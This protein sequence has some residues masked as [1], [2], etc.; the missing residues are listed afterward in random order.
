MVTLKR[1]IRM[2]LKYSVVRSNR[3]TVSM[4]ITPE[5][6]VLIRA[7]R[8]MSESAIE[9]FASEHEMWAEEHIEKMRLRMQNHPEPDDETKKILREK[10][11][12]TIPP[13]VEK[14]AHLMGVC[15]TGIKIT[16]A[17]KRFGSCS[18][19]NSLCFSLRLMMYPPEAVEYVVVHELA[20]IRYKN[21]GCEF[22]AFIER[23]MPDYKQ[24][25]KLLRT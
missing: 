1:G 3:K 8:R 5:L 18:G 2:K 15:P 4:E 9:R 17:K 10:A 11:K 21:H 13:L 12:K 20:H 22:Y 16:D 14:Y 23:F 25:I 7:P 19:K 24:R 6:T